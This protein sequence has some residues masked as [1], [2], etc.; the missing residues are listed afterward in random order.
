MPLLRRSAR[1]AAVL[2]GLL[3]A[4]VLG[5]P[6]ATASPTTASP[7]AASQTATATATATATPQDVLLVGWS[8]GW[9][10]DHDAVGRE[11][12]VRRVLPGLLD[13]RPAGVLDDMRQLVLGDLPGTGTFDLVQQDPDAG[14]VRFGSCS[15]GTPVQGQVVV[16]ELSAGQDG[17]PDVLAVDL[18]WRCGSAGED[19][20]AVVRIS[21]AVPY[22]R[23]EVSQPYVTRVPNEV[24]EVVVGDVRST[25]TA[26]AALV[27]P[28]GSNCPEVLAP[29]E[30]CRIERE[31]RGYDAG[32]IGP[33]NGV[34]VPV[35]SPG[36]VG[37]RGVLTYRPVWPAAACTTQVSGRGTAAV[38]VW[39]HGCESGAAEDLGVV[40]ER[41]GPR[42]WA[43]LAE[44]PDPFNRTVEGLAPGEEVTLRSVLST[45]DQATGA[46]GRLVSEPVS[47][48]AA[49]TAYLA[50]DGRLSSSSDGDAGAA[51]LRE[52]VSG[53]DV[54]SDRRTRALV[55]A[56][57]STL[58]L[59]RRD[60]TLVREVAFTEY[61]NVRRPRFSPDGRQVALT[62]SGPGGVVLVDVAS[63]VRRVV[64]AYGDVVQGWSPDGA[65]V[66]VAGSLPSAGSVRLLWLDI[67]TGVRTPVPG[68]EGVEYAAVSR[69]G[70]VAFV[71]Q[72]PDRW[73]VL[74]QRAGAPARTV[75]SVD[76][77]LRFHR[78]VRYS[79][80][81]QHLLV[82]RSE[83]VA[84]RDH[85]VAVVDVRT[86]STRLL[87][88]PRLAQLAWDQVGSAPPATP[89]VSV[90]AP[91]TG[92]RTQVR[93]TQSDPDDAAPAL[94]ARCRVDAGAW[95]A[96]RSPWQSPRLTQGRHTAAV[97]L[98][99]PA[100]TWSAVGTTTWTVRGSE[101]FGRLSDW[102]GDGVADPAGYEGGRW[103]LP[104]RVVR[105]GVAGDV[106]VAADYDGDG[107]ADVAVYR[108]STGD[109]YVKGRPPVR[110][111][112]RGD[113]PVVAD[114]TG[115]GRA[116][117]AVF[118][119]STGEW[120][121]RG[122]PTV[123]YG[124][125]GDVPVQADYDGDGRADVAMFRP[126]TGEWLVRGRP[127]VRHGQR[128]D[129]PV[130]ADYDGDGRADVAVFRPGP[131]TWSVRGR[132]AVGYGMSGAQPVPA[133][134]T[135]DGR[136][137]FAVL[138]AGVWYL[139][140][141][142]PV[143]ASSGRAVAV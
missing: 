90:V 4:L 18:T 84:E 21:S 121:V 79:P 5:A 74:E 44:G 51:V 26:P 142:A 30:S 113:V 17:I 58:R 77:R 124:A 120:L 48:R 140:G 62:T 34:V 10:R 105:H 139:Q 23:L 45:R 27:A 37:T 89:A 60:G 134:Y 32:L 68:T 131:R 111:G 3:P 55:A 6:A 2:A 122:R 38:G 110:H 100:G 135:G 59:E 9:A 61:E 24:T 123:R 25:G 12:E 13:Y 73:T 112:A 132:A 88:G 19:R 119:P 136:A 97:Q 98:R 72:D 118:R 7:A 42:G 86:G 80:D 102:T 87:P 14:Q 127:T 8:Q 82:A 49:T 66:L 76:G 99:D 57:S 52:D 104:G 11:V 54:S 41:L 31:V 101:A 116:D 63:G 39:L 78:D 106:P 15:S 133:D 109:W 103:D 56:G 50:A 143:A 33:D 36:G 114:Y 81:G 115:D 107:R 141:R 92:P 129:V 64:D 1:P 16:H 138:K 71:R 117:M 43:P 93:W 70:A 108:P 65:R 22:A 53:V 29:G 91:V 85:G 47:A 35:D 67:A 128:G 46:L 75:T 96:C 20:A 137:D 126:S 83:Q 94:T 28:A 40:V 130:P 125:R 69:D 95:T